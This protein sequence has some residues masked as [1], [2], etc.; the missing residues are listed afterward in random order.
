MFTLYLIS[1]HM[2]SASAIVVRVSAASLVTLQ[3]R[4]F[5]AQ[6]GQVGC[7]QSCCPK[8]VLSYTLLKLEVNTHLLCSPGRMNLSYIL[9]CLPAFPSYLK[10]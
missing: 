10:Q 7:F 1:A 3:Q 6:A 5:R 9:G 4:A 8:D 2:Q